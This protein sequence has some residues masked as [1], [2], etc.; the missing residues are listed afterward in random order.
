MTQLKHLLACAARGW[1]IFP[2]GDGKTPLLGS[3]GLLD[4]TTDPDKLTSW[5]TERPGRNWGLACGPSNLLVVD[6]DRHKA[7]SDGIAAWEKLGVECSPILE[8]ETPSG[9]RH[10]YFKGPGPSTAGR[11]APGIDTRGNGGYV[12]LP[13]SQIDGKPYKAIRAGGSG[14]LP[15]AVADL[16]AGRQRLEAKA[17]S[18]AVDTPVAIARAAELLRAAAPAVEG[19]GGDAHTYRLACQLRDQGLSEQAAID[20]MS[21]IWNPRCSPPWEQDELASKVANAYTYAQLPAGADGG[22]PGFAAVD[23]DLLEEAK[24]KGPAI[25]AA[26]GSQLDAM[27][28]PP[29]PWVLGHDLI[30]GFISAT[31]A[32]GGV[33]KSSI[34]LLEAISVASGRSL[35]GVPVHQK[36]AVWIHN[37]EDPQDELARRTIAA[38]QHHHV[39]LQELDDLHLTS[40]RTAPLILAV[41]NRGEV[42]ENK[43]A[44]AAIEQYLVEH[45]IL[46]WVLDP[47]V[48]VHMCDENSNAEMAHVMLILGRIAENTGCCISLVHH[49]NKGGAEGDMN[50]ARGASAFGGAV[51]IMRTVVTMSQ[52]DAEQFGLDDKRRKW[53]MRLDDAKGNMAA[54]AEEAR[55]FEKHDHVLPNGDHVGAVAVAK[56]QAVQSE[57]LTDV[58]DALLEAVQAGKLHPEVYRVAEVALVL[59][60]LDKEVGR[61]KGWRQTKIA[62]KITAVLEGA[63][64]VVPRKLLTLSLNGYEVTVARTAAGFLDD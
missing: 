50:S 11:I 32:Q 51:R 24:P 1:Y 29:R 8:V 19:S 4:A 13:G 55:W 48:H 15:Q 7:D 18:D 38:A 59:K 34:T 20:L 28:I 22:N 36:G 54:P 61:F 26:R 52:S 9:G 33:G 63:K 6:L 62:E 37:T 43:P 41:G 16:L 35:T 5:H 17:Q 58:R 2:L 25:H 44:I 45:N 12:L 27:S 60:D 21:A 10:L 49:K 47:F 64:I 56:L 23:D 46:V 3:R 53:F 57:D 14:E 42:T 31:V 30:R 39:P 40:G